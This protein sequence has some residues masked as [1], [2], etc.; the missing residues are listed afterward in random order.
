MCNDKNEENKICKVCGENLPIDK[1]ELIKSK[2]RKTYH[3]STCRK[4]RYKMRITKKYILNDNIKN[5]IQRKYKEIKPERVLDLSLTNIELAGNDEI[6]VK[7]MDYKNVWISNYGRVIRWSSDQYNLLKGSLSTDGTVRYSVSKNILVNGKWI[8]KRVTLYA[9]QE[10]VKEFV[11]NPDTVNN[12][13]IWHVKNNKVDNYYKHLYPLNKDQYYAVKWHYTKFGD[14][15][16]KTILKIMNDIRFASQDYSIRSMKPIMCNRGYQGRDKVN[17]K[18]KAYI[19]WHDMMNRCYNEKFHERQP[20]YKECFV[21]D[22]WWSFNNF[23]KW[24]NDNFYETDNQTMD[25]DKDILFKGNN[26]YSPSTCCIIPHSINTLFLT[27]KKK[28]GNMP[29]GIYFEKEQNKY[30]VC[31][32]YGGISKKLGRFS[33]IEEA[34]K[35]YKIY[36]EKLINDIAKQYRGKIPDKVYQAMLDWKVEI[37]D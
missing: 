23:E 22:E 18:S 28:R 31:I 6:F 37:T 20:Q 29:I 24:Y 11:V 10:V 26:E 27:G 21:C 14:D 34:F 36:K 16:E 35:Q 1:F 2:E 9:A 12:V 5:I 15:S 25:L 19:R 33:D 32:S 30:R 3:I 13:W 17:C 7:L 8:Y 4:C